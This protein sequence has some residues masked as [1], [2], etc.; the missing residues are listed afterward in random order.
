MK[1]NAIFGLIILTLIL[2]TACEKETYDY[3]NTIYGVNFPGYQNV[4]NFVGIN[5]VNGKYDKRSKVDNF[6]GLAYASFHARSINRNTYIYNC[7]YSAIGLIDLSTLKVDKIDVWNDTTNARICSLV[8]DESKNILY[9]IATTYDKHQYWISIIPIDLITKKVLSKIDI[10]QQ[11]DTIHYN[12]IAD[13]DYKD[14]RIFI[15]PITGSF[16]YIYNYQSKSIEIKPFDINLMDINYDPKKDRLFGTCVYI[17]DGFYLVSY[18]LQN[19][20]I[21]NIVKIP[22]ITFILN[23]CIYYNRNNESYWIGTRKDKIE[24]LKIDVANASIVQRIS[25]NEPVKKLN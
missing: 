6:E 17:D 1:K 8:V 25:L 2:M 12:F 19:G 7:T 13:I 9:V 18:S 14:K 5:L 24:L 4:E 3:E 10:I 22:Q 15:K 20:I 21:N 16:I 23:D 11:K